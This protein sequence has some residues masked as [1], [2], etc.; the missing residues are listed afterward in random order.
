MM[1]RRYEQVE[2]Q[3]SPAGISLKIVIRS[4]WYL[5]VWD[6]LSGSS[7]ETKNKMQTWDR[8]GH[9]IIGCLNAVENEV[10]RAR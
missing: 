3:R 7:R 9:L 5:C 4:S 8:N 10:G 1:T 2:V 6:L